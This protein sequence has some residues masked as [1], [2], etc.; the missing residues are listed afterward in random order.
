MDYTKLIRK[1]DKIHEVLHEQKNGS[2]I[3]SKE[4]K[5]YIPLR[6]T[7][8]NLAYVGTDNYILGIYAIV[9]EDMFYGVSLVNAMIPIDPTS[10]NKV[11]IQD[12]VYLEFI[13]KPGS[14]VFKSTDLVKTNTITYIIFDEIFSKGYI[15]WYVGYEELG[16]ITLYR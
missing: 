3:C 9:V 6:F 5:I 12:D 14:V 8:R 4:C 10:T 13:F 15:P 1:P 11:K 2:V 16:R 7:E